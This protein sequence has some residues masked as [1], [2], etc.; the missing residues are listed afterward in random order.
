[1]AWGKNV[2][3]SGLHAFDGFTGYPDCVFDASID[4]YADRIDTSIEDKPFTEVL[5]QVSR[6]HFPGDRLQT[7]HGGDAALN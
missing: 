7:L 6:L 4:Q 2:A 1:M 3:A 5:F